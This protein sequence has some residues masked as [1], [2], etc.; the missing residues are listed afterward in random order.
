MNA[1]DVF[2]VIVRTIGLLV[3]LAA[4][5]Q[6]AVALLTLVAGGPG[7]AL[8]LLLS[9]IPALLL[10]LWLLSGAKFLIAYAYPKKETNQ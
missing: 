2:G 6:I 4:L 7:N 8:A 5:W 3:L 10:G 9:G 1:S